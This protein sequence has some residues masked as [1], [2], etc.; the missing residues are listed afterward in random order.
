MPAK[1]AKLAKTAS[2]K[3]RPYTLFSN[4]FRNAE[5]ARNAQNRHLASHDP[6]RL[7]LLGS[8]PDMVHG[9]SL[10]KTRSSAHTNG[11]AIRIRS[12]KRDVTPAV[13]D[14]RY[15][16]PLSP[17]PV[18]SYFISCCFWES[19]TGIFPL[20]R[21]R[22]DSIP[23]LFFFFKSFLKFPPL[24]FGKGSKSEPYPPKAK[25]TVRTAS[26]SP[27]NG[28]VKRKDTPNGAN[29]LPRA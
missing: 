20:F 7:M 25:N 17:R 13:A 28:S 4:C 8:P 19:V 5:T 22:K 18:W 15:R 16:A 10:R 14:C 23:Q 26:G 21:I 2:Y 9:R 12:S 6:L 24:F 29:T 27:R 11:A 1:T 3:I